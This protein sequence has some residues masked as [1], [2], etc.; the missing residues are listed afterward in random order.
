MK[1][2]K[3]SA[4]STTGTTGNLTIKPGFSRSGGAHEF[5]NFA[6]LARDLVKVPKTAVDKQRRDR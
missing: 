2:A 3:V 1:Q 6:D 4:G 5:Q